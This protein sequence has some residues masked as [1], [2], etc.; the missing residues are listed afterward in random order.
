MSGKEM[1]K[2]DC[3]QEGQISGLGTGMDCGSRPG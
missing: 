3:K 1:F 2:V